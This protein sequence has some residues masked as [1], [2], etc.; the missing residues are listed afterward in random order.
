MR[1]SVSSVFFVPMLNPSDVRNHLAHPSHWRVGRS[2]ERLATTWLNSA[3]IPQS[4]RRV[5][6]SEVDFRNIEP[7]IGAF[8]HTTRL[9][10][11]PRASQTDLMLVARLRSQSAKSSLAVIAVE[12]KVDETF[13]LPVVDKRARAKTGSRWPQRL[14]GLCHSLELN[15]EAVER[16]PYQLIHRTAAALIEAERFGA[17][18]A[19]FLVHSFAKDGDG[20]RLTEFVSFAQTLGL[21]GAGKNRI[22]ETIKRS[23]VS[24]RLAWVSEY[25]S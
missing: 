3:G 8:E 21:R 9:D 13:D 12:G 20:G 11:F 22:S 15:V 7:L 1:R 16:T 2:A 19:V 10:A 23:G 6:E 24:L 25:A 18:E 14:E 4:V 5:L 17:G